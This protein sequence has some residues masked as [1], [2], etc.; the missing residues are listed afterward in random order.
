MLTRFLKKLTIYA[1]VN[2]FSEMKAGK[3]D[4]RREARQRNADLVMAHIAGLLPETYR[5]YYAGTAV[6]PE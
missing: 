6:N 3:G 1:N 5:G 2:I 4:E